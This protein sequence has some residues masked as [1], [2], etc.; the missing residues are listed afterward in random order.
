MREARPG[1]ILR[2][3]D[4]AAADWIAAYVFEFLDRLDMVPHVEVI[5]TASPESHVSGF[6]EPLGDLLLQHL[7]NDREL[8]FARLADHQ[9]NMLR[10]DDVTGD[11][12][13]VTVP[14]FLQ[15]FLKDGVPG[16]G[17]EQW[18]SVVTTEG[19]EVEMARVLIAE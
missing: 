1:P 2:I 7:Q 15:F 10:H 6:L 9:M 18:L 14:D 13:A 17:L 12:Q 19:E 8:R 5:V 4:Q 3:G 16:S 11:D